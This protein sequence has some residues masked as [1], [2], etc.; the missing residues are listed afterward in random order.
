MC[1]H[2]VHYIICEHIY[3]YVYIAHLSPC[4]FM[5]IHIFLSL[6]LYICMMCVLYISRCAYLIMFS[7]GYA[8]LATYW[9]LLKTYENCFWSGRVGS[10][11]GSEVGSPNEEVPGAF[12]R[13]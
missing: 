7:F 10:I 4:N 13:Q 12:S 3:I 11:P 2:M 5:Y 6:S 8:L 9:T 1:S